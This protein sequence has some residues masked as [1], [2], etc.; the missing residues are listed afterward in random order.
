MASSPA[1]P[2]L[3]RA[4]DSPLRRRRSATP[5]PSWAMKRKKGFLPAA[6]SHRCAAS[7]VSALADRRSLV[8]PAR[9]RRLSL[10]D[11]I[12]TAAAPVLPGRHSRSAAATRLP[13]QGVFRHKGP[14]TSSCISHRRRQDKGGKKPK[15]VSSQSVARTAARHQDGSSAT[16][17][18]PKRPGSFIHGSHTSSARP[19]LSSGPCEGCPLPNWGQV[20]R[21]R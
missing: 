5:P 7:P 1:S 12:P 13:R 8:L 4:R 14:S 19:G 6:R 10:R 18:G 11:E 15:G 21:T 3:A 17:G 16:K 2:T 20:R 9:E